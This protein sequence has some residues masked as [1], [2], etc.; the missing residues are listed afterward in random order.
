M[1]WG[2]DARG[3]CAGAHIARIDEKPA[4]PDGWNATSST[5]FGAG[6]DWGRAGAGYSRTKLLP[7]RLRLA[8]AACGCGTRPSAVQK[9]GLNPGRLCRAARAATGGTAVGEAT[10]V[11]YDRRRGLAA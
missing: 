1:G 9:R 2:R 3:G 7:T 10:A 8:A 11:S 5:A 4:K 6:W